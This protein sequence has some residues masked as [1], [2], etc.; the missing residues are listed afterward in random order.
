MKLGMFMMLL[1]NPARDLTEVLA[2]G[3]D[4]VIRADELDMVAT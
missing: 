2:E 1:Y 3:R 4:L